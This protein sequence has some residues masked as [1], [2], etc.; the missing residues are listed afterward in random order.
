MKRSRSDPAQARARTH[1]PD[2]KVAIITGADGGIS[3]AIVTAYRDL[4]YAVVAT[5]RSMPDA[6]DPQVLAFCGDLTESGVGARITGAAM[7]RFGRIDTV[8]NSA[9]VFFSNGLARS[10]ARDL[11]RPDQLR[12]AAARKLN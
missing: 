4:G 7:D 8:V 9:G 6:D 10:R 1:K 11:W 5:S 12:Q 2:P 3:S